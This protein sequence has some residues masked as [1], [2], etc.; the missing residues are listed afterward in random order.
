MMIAL[1]EQVPIV[2]CGVYSFGWSPRKR[3]PCAVVWGEPLDLSGLPRSGRGY[4]EAAE[5]VGAEILRLWRLAAEAVAA[6][7]PDDLPDGSRRLPGRYVFFTTGSMT[8]SS[9]TSV[10]KAAA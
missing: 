4:K 5:I 2:P 3:T 9:S 10:K 8:P 1:Q 6:G 7:F